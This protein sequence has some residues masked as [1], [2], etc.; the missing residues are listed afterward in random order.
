MP[1]TLDATGSYRTRVP[2]RQ[3]PRKTAVYSAQRET[4]FE[5]EVERAIFEEWFGHD[6]GKV[7]RTDHDGSGGPE[8]VHDEES[9]SKRVRTSVDSH[10]PIAGPRQVEAT[11]ELVKSME[12][13]VFD[14][15]E[16]LDSLRLT[17]IVPEMPASVATALAAPVKTE[18]EKRARLANL[19][20][21]DVDEV[22][23]KMKSNQIMRD[24]TYWFD[25]LYRNAEQD[26][27]RVIN[28]IEDT[29]QPILGDIY[30]LSK[31][32]SEVA[33]LQAFNL[34]TLFAY[35]CIN[36]PKALQS[37]PECS[38]DD[39]LR[40]L[41]PADVLAKHC[42]LKL[43]KNKWHQFFDW[44]RYVKELNAD[45]ADAKEW[46]ARTDYLQRTIAFIR[47]I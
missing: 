23:A 28:I 26:P 44:E 27:A 42:A 43:W 38:N 9:P 13:Y 7:D 18:T 22:L 4:E 5:S 12:S 32:H 8:I 19:P 24:L 39:F 10:V 2:R 11:S 14:M 40:L 29:T 25:R 17:S 16:V 21:E 34:S 37:S 36:V 31:A 20:K 33:L 1:R 45:L 35:H 46:F 30:D 41:E 47:Q 3:L 15:E 6:Y